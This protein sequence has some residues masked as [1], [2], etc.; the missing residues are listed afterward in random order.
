MTAATKK[1]A[2]T[3]SVRELVEFVLRR[4]DLVTEREF[5]GSDRALAGIR[6]HQKIQR[7]RPA[8][9]QTEI[10]VK[11]EVETTEFTL[12]IRGRIDGLFPGPGEMWLEEIKTVA[13]F[14]DRT[15]DPLHWAQARF[16]AFLHAREHSLPEL[17]TLLTYLE[18][19]T[20]KITEFRQTFSF[21]ELQ[22]FFASTIAVY[23][24]WLREQHHWCQLRNESVRQLAF[25]FP[26]YR[27]GQRELAV[28][29]YRTLAKGGRLFLSAPTGIGKTISTLF[30]AVKALGVGKLERI[31]YLTARTI[32]R[33]VAEKAGADL[34]QGGVKLRTVTLTARE[35]VCVQSGQ[36][37]D[38]LTCPLA[39]G[40]YDRV[41]P[42]IREALELQAI[43][44]AN[45]DIV[46]RK[47]QV[48]P[49]ELS[50][51]VSQWSDVVICDYNY[52]FDPKVYLRRH[53]SETSNHYGLLVDEAHNLV[54]RARE[55]FSADLNAADIVA[56]RKSLKQSVPRCA[57]A[58]GKLSD[59]L[60]KLAIGSKVTGEMSEASDPA[61]ELN[62]FP[63]KIPAKTA[64]VKSEKGNAQ[65]SQAI[66]EK[67]IAL[68]EEALVET[69]AWLA[70]NQPATFR[71]ELLSLYFQLNSFQRTAEI[72][73]DHFTTIIENNDGARVKLFCLDPSFLLRQ[74][75]DRSHAAVFFS[76]TLTPIDYYR[77]LL[78]GEANDATLQLASPFPPD[79]LAVLI[80]DTIQ[81]H[82]KGRSASLGKVADAIGAT[83]QGRTGNY[84]VYFPSYQYLNSV[85]AEFQSR[86]P[87]IRCLVQQPTMT[88]AA[89]ADF[90]AAFWA[91]HPEILV[92]FAVLGGIFGEGIDLVGEHLIGA[93][94]VGVG[95]P[96]LSIER[97]LIRDYFDQ[98]NGDGFNYAYTFPGMNRVL[99]AVGRVIRSETDRGVVL[100]IDARFREPRY[101]RLFPA[102]WQTARV[103]DSAAIRQLTDVF[104]NKT[105]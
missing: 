34:R 35:K 57:R 45:L 91:K 46:A 18:L 55:M 1:P 76:A 13:S 65:V 44:Q 11:Y 85:L 90:L 38:P 78:G 22:E 71:E 47:H 26:G 74:S 54:D 60:R 94:I 17:T 66:P 51:D 10:P 33:S 73:D 59:E 58:L 27:A 102:W 68:L 7:S 53:F 88:E 30:P 39:L 49:F 101:R 104:W 86:H 36:P 12:L 15:A 50:L 87:Q 28:A 2:H 62:L 52:V 96:Q 64:L 103:G 79:H 41:K 37:C 56:V 70:Q 72:Y 63:A 99:Q 5:V 20:G 42:A 95:L 19:K 84:L 83:V 4:G 9:Y 14:W 93:V 89:R 21:V 23:V 8:G 16:Y 100:L 81:T 97:D 31:F 105:Y 48:C 67:L 92:G 69:E 3:V 40:Y 6:G 82:F 77:T 98:R 75:L 25:P 32:G 80:Q 24:D 29:A 43:N 61:E